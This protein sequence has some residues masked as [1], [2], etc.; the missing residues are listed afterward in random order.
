MR[1]DAVDERR[2]CSREI[3][4]RRDFGRAIVLRGGYEHGRYDTH[5]LLGR[6]GDHDADAIDD[7]GA[8]GFPASIG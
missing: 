3:A 5:R 8:R 1:S 2:I 6:A 4:A 7:T